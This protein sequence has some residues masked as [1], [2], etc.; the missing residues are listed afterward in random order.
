MTRNSQIESLPEWCEKC[1]KQGFYFPENNK[2]TYLVIHKKCRYEFLNVWCEHCQT[3]FTL[4]TINMRKSETWQCPSCYAKNQIN[5]LVFQNPI[6]L[7]TED[8]LAEDVRAKSVST[9]HISGFHVAPLSRKTKLIW[10]RIFLVLFGTYILLT[11]NLFPFTECLKSDLF[12]TEGVVIGYGCNDDGCES[13]NCSL[14][15]CSSKYAIIRFTDIYGKSHI[16]SDPNENLTGSVQIQY[17]IMKFPWRDDYSVSIGK[18]IGFERA[19]SSI[20]L[21]LA[22]IFIVS[23]ITGYWF[24]IPKKNF[25]LKLR[26]YY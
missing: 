5:H 3:G 7:C 13:G 8:K 26:K 14:A 24:G 11:I 9:P 22:V 18:D 19:V 15:D 17:Q 4:P 1:N 21:F 12:Q 10:S 23:G 20:M 16:G 2:L 6:E 25:K